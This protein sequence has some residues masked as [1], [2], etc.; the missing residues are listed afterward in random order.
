MIKVSCCIQTFT[1]KNLLKA[2]P[3]GPPPREYKQ[4]MAMYETSPHPGPVKRKLDKK[5][6]IILKLSHLWESLP[7]QHSEKE[8]YST[9]NEKT[10]IENTLKKIILKQN[11]GPH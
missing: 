1:C 7:I 10:I 5:W 8:K 6:L 9:M 4:S 3:G 2:K 11:K